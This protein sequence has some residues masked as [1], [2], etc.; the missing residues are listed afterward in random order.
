MEDI[1]DFD[2]L[3]LDQHKLARQMTRLRVRLNAFASADA[4][5]TADGVTETRNE[6]LNVQCQQ[7]IRNLQVEEFASTGTLEGSMQRA[8]DFIVELAGSD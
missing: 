5:V 7:W 3:V 4:E 1:L 8:I 6:F 2:E